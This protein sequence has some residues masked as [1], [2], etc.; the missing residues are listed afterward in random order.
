LAHDG[1]ERRVGA[2]H[3]YYL[4]SYYIGTPHRDN[5]QIVRVASHPGD[6]QDPAADPGVVV[7][8]PTA[9]AAQIAAL[10]REY[11]EFAAVKNILVMWR[12]QVPKQSAPNS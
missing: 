8:S 6:R 3:D 12:E 7:A 4:V 2:C 1:Q 9:A 5:V 10:R 11:P